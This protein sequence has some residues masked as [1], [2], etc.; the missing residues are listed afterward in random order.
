MRYPCLILDHDDTLVDSTAH[1]HWPAF[2]KGM[3]QLRPGITMTLD[4]YFA[5]NCDPGI[6][7]YYSEV[8]KL[9]PDEM[10]AEKKIWLDYVATHTPSVYPGMEKIIRRQKELGGAVCV[11]SQSFTENILRDYQL[12]GLPAPDLVFGGERPE[13]ERKPTPWPV[14]QIL[15]RLGFTP[16]QA[17]VV[18]DLMPGLEM[19]KAAGVDFAAACW[20][21]NLP[22][23]RAGMECSAHYCCYTPDDLYRLLFEEPTL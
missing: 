14:E 2:L 12:H 7:R 8:V 18:D 15:S 22:A 11:V 9:N 6:Y 20:A 10:A 19:A 17:L 5:M 16:E 21:H 23:I 13:A 1:L 3:E 4:E